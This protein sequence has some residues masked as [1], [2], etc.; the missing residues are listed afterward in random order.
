MRV[1]GRK[2][3][4]IFSLFTFITVLPIKAQSQTGVGELLFIPVYMF[5]PNTKC[6]PVFPEGENSWHYSPAAYSKGTVPA[7]LSANI[8]PFIDQRVEKHSNLVFLF[9]RRGGVF[10]GIS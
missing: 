9:I 7:K 6:F 10:N 4:F 5:Y 8:R 3:L 2:L 1:L